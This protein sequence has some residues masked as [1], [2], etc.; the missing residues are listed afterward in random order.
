MT[1]AFWPMSNGLR[2]R[3][4]SGA[5][6]VVVGSSEAE[7]W[8]LAPGRGASAGLAR[9]KCQLEVS[10]AAQLPMIRLAIR[11]P[12]GSKWPN[13]TGNLLFSILRLL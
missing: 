6:Q 8:E 12:I 3:I 9:P 2:R 10:S 4:T 1:L 7:R 13:K 11:R 5:Q